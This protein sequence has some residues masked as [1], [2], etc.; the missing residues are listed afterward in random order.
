MENVAIVALVMGLTQVAKNYIDTRHVPLLSVL[1]GLILGLLMEGFSITGSMVGIVSGLVA[2]G[3]YDN[4][5]QFRQ[6]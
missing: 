4:V 2:S 5:T 1:F 3:L 6:N